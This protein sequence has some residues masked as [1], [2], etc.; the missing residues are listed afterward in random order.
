MRDLFT[1]TLDGRNASLAP[2]LAALL[3]RPARDFADRRGRRPVGRRLAEP[4]SPPTDAKGA[5]VSRGPSSS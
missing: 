3:G 1:Q 4:R 5:A 2:D